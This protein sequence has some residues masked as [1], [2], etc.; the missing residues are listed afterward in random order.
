MISMPAA[1]A[2]AASAAMSG[3]SV[4][5]GGIA[6]SLAGSAIARTNT[7]KPA[8]SATSG[9]RARSELTTNVCGMLRG[10]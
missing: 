1:A 5:A 8:G 10:P 9:K 3:G 7:S 2:A 6:C 4:A